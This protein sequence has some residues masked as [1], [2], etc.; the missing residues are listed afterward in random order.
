MQLSTYLKAF[1]L[2]T[3]HEDRFL[4][5]STLRS[6]TALVSGQTL[7]ALAQGDL[8]ESEA[9][10]LRQLGMVTDDGI[11]ERE[12]MRSLLARANAGHSRF[13]TI[14]VLNL[15]CNLDCGY[16]YEGEF[17]G[18][19]YMSEATALQL[20]EFLIRNQMATGKDVTVSFY[21]GEPLLSEDLITLISRPLLQ[22][23]RRHGVRYDCTLVTNGTLLDREMAKRL[24]PFGLKM[25]KFTLDGPREIHDRQRPFASGSGSFDAIVDNI[26]AVWDLVPI[27]LGSN[28]YRENYR[29]FPRLLDDLIE[30]GV[31]P[32]KLDKVQFVPV[33]PKAGCAEKGSGCSCAGEPWLTE[34]LPYLQQEIVARGFAT[35]KLKVSAC[36]V[37]VTDNVVV[38]VDGALYKC[39]AFMGWKELKVGTLADG[40]ADYADSHGIG[41][42]QNEACLG[43]AYLPI[44]FGGCRFSNLLQ[45]K[46]VG[47]LDCRKQFLDDTLERYVRLQV[48]QLREQQGPS[49]G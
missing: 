16:C 31:T 28:F 25:A 2:G 43:C 7:R 24:L 40:L 35:N 5:Y 47:D 48:P 30:R 9:G 26:L 12:E 46:A 29:Q 33:M 22:A 41:N 23:A 44:C 4:L 36:M 37:E 1:P 49:Y 45:D 10:T 21:G 34:A 18:N 32:E 8:P 3:P 20:V 42:W 15:D 17:R 14:A 6:S 13:K 11:R 38:G 27:F 19:S 39:P